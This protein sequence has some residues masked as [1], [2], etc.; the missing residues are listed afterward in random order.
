MIFLSEP[1][2]EVIKIL[3]SQA[4]SEF[5]FELGNELTTFCGLTF[6][7][8]VVKTSAIKMLTRRIINNGNN[9]TRCLMEAA[10]R[11]MPC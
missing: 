6:R 2:F 4:M 1:H 8:L 7:D 5:N 11:V 9:I 3:L 10:I